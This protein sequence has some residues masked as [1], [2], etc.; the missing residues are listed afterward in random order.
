VSS[1]TLQVPQAGALAWRRGL[2]SLAQ[3]RCATRTA[4]S[5]W[6]RVYG[7]SAT[8]LHAGG[9]PHLVRKRVAVRLGAL[10]WRGPRP[11]AVR[12]GLTEV[13][14]PR[15][16]PVGP[17]R[18]VDTHTVACRE[19]HT[20]PG[21]DGFTS[22]DGQR[23]APVQPAAPRRNQPLSATVAVAVAVAAVT[24]PTASLRPPTS[25]PLPLGHGRPSS[26]GSSS[27]SS[28]SNPLH[29]TRPRGTCSLLPHAEPPLV[30]LNCACRRWVASPWSLM[31]SGAAPCVRMTRVTRN[32]LPYSNKS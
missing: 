1:G 8:L 9:K 7:A 11:L 19:L 28:P 16:G 2:Q 12:V 27:S 4:S 23:R 32:N 14:F 3:P 26:T 10:S 24:S 30:V 22:H 25:C 17:G 31:E 13:C 29:R 21:D 20:N 6:S 5:P 18:Q 15:G